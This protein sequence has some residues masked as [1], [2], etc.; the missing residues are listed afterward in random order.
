MLVANKFAV[1]HFEFFM[2]MNVFKTMTNQ[3]VLGEV[4]DNHRTNQGQSFSN[5]TDVYLKKRMAAL[6]SM[7][8]HLLN[9][10]F[11]VVVDPVEPGQHIFKGGQ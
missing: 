9:V 2:N 1:K 3:Y 7:S 8:L 10:V 4:N 5:T 11:V 6:K